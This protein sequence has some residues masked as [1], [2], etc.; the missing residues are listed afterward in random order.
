MKTSYHI[1]SKEVIAYSIENNV[2]RLTA[3][4]ILIGR[5]IGIRED[6]EEVYMKVF[7]ENMKLYITVEEAI[8]MATIHIILQDKQ[9][10][11]HSNNL[12][13]SKN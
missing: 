6:E 10:E 5:E 4:A 13:F 7:D 12:S 11:E 2:T 1:N 8:E 9:Q 3:M